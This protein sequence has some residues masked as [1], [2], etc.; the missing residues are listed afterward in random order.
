MAN[1]SYCRF[2]NTAQDL[3]DCLDALDPYENE[4]EIN[5]EE[6]Q[7]G[8]RMFENF[9]GYC[10]DIGLID[11]YDRDGIARHFE[12]HNAAIKANKGGDEE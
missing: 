11:E 4:Y 2:R 8:I 10:Q 1:M 6:T 12:E 3:R 5:K 9:L 7:A